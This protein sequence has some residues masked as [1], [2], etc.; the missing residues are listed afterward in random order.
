MKILN[1][2]YWKL[3][4]S[5]DTGSGN[6]IDSSGNGRNGTTSGLASGD[7]DTTDVPN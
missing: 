6:V 4:A 2:G 1:R 3:N 5:D 7:F